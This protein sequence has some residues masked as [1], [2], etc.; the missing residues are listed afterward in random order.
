MLV[1]FSDPSSLIGLRFSIFEFMMVGRISATALLEC[2]MTSRVGF[3][4]V[5]GRKAT[6]N[7]EDRKTSASRAPSY[8]KPAWS[9]TLP[10]RNVN[11]WIRWSK[12]SANCR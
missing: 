3:L 5:K 9:C 11:N 7:R 1:N 10:G 6:E 12:P 2:I 4:P 8:N